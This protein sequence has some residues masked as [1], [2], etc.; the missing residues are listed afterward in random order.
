MSTPALRF[1]QLVKRYAG[2]PVLEGIDL[3]I[4]PG[5]CV[6]LVGVNGAGKTSLLKC[7]FDFVR[8]DSGS[9]DIFG[10]SHRE[11]GARG[12]LAFLPERFMPPYYLSGAEFLAYMA[13]LHG[14]RYDSAEARA[15]LDALELDHAALAMPARKQSKGMTQKLGL[16]ACFLANKQAYVLD[17]PMSG[18]DPKARARLKER[19]Q[20]ARSQGATVFFS[21]HALADIEELC[22]RMAI[23]HGGRLRFIGTPAACRAAYHAATLEQAFLA[24]VN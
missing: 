21:S 6:G 22:D 13:K 18:L 9:I 19:L 7:L 16:A 12:A 8:V 17:E 20:H 5:E 3:D 4:A 24:C 2:T 15:M 11:P 14:N 1:R 10:R 23:L